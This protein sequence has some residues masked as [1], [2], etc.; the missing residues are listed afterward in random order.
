MGPGATN[1]SSPA[2][3]LMNSF[4]LVLAPLAIPAVQNSALNLKKIH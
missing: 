4:F 1:T 3:L 2:N